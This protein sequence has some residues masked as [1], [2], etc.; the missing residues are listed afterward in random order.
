M[1]HGP[2]GQSLY[3]E[4]SWVSWLLPAGLRRAQVH[5]EGDQPLLGTVVQLVV[6][7]EGGSLSASPWCSARG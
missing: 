3:A 5:G 7:L 4:R 1:H 2:S 6:G